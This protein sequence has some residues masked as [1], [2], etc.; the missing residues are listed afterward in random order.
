M[1]ISELQVDA[2][3]LRFLLHVLGEGG[4]PVALVADL[5]EPYRNCE[6]K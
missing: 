6:G 2:F 1:R 5:G 3:F 4:T